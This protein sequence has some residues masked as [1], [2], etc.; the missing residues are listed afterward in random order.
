MVVSKKVK[1]YYNDLENH[2]TCSEG[3]LISKDDVK[4]V[5][6]DSYGK[7]I[8]IPLMKIVRVEEEK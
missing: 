2:V 8:T 6:E 4:F 1:V 3:K 7:T 5:L